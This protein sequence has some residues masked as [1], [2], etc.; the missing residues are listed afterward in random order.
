MSTHTWKILTN[1]DRL[2]KRFPI[3]ECDHVNCVRIDIE[4][5][6]TILFHRGPRWYYMTVDRNNNVMLR[7]AQ[8]YEYCSWYTRIQEGN[9]SPFEQY[10]QEQDLPE[11]VNKV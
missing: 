2:Q 5:T 7:R 4:G 11:G 1:V 8:V 6:Q 3:K 10:Y 9:L